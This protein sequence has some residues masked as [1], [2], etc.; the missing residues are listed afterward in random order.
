MARRARAVIGA[1]FGDEG[2]GLTVDYL[3][4]VQGAGVVIRF[5]GGAQAGHTVVTPDGRR[6]VFSHVGSGAFCGVPTYLSEFF[7]TN[8]LVLLKELDALNKIGVVPTVFASPKCYVTTFADMLI[9]QRIEDK[10]AGSRHGSVGLGVGETWE[11]SQMKHL[12]ITM[13]DIWNGNVGVERK[14]KEICDKYAKFRTGKEIDR[15]DE[16][17]DAFLRAC[18]TMA[19]YVHP[20]G[21]SECFDADPIFE[22]AQGLLLD[23]NNKDFF[24]HVTRSNTGLKN[25]L[26][27]CGQMGVKPDEIEP[28]FVSRTYV[29]RHGAGPL[30]GEDP[31]M[32]YP[33]DTNLEHPYQGALRFAKIDPVSLV[34]RLAKESAPVGGKYKLVL[35]HCDQHEPAGLPADLYSYGPTRVDVEAVRR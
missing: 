19:K 15:A 4:D 18:E 26:A 33:D 23:Q 12:E 2:K 30:P 14:L 35:T 22:G 10:R 16:M 20:L 34:A 31:R 17:I 32:S 7:I 29:T 21:I 24:P 11:R 8:P 27:L 9:N 1:A 28:Y 6:H 13:G 25:V 5:N 3:C